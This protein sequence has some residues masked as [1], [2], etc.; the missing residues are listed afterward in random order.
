MKLE[1]LTLDVEQQ[2]DIKAPR[3]RYFPP[4]WKGSGRKIPGPMA[5]L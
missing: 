1:D 5:N 2:I 3:K 4:Y